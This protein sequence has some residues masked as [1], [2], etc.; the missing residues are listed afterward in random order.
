MRVIDFKTGRA[1]PPSAE[2]LPPGHVAQMQVLG[3][4]LDIGVLVL[5][6]LIPG[7]STITPIAGTLIARGYGRNEELAADRHAVELLQ[8]AGYSRQALIAALSWIAA[9]SDGDGGGFLSTHPATDDRIEA[10]KSGGAGS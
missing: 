9:S 3:A 5:E 2:S 7:S 4:G 6:Q 10:L 1:I 8:R